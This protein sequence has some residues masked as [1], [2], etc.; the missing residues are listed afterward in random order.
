[1]G[2]RDVKIGADPLR[3]NYCTNFLTTLISMQ[4]IICQPLVWRKALVVQY[5][6]LQ[7]HAKTEIKSH[8]IWRKLEKMIIHKQHTRY[9]IQEWTQPTFEILTPNAHAKNKQKT[10]Q[11]THTHQK[12]TEFKE[13]TQNFH[14][15]SLQSLQ[16]NKANIQRH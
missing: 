3:R 7:I 6:E 8:V 1:M 2:F 13:K 9:R 5:K 12:A 10:K 11:Q 15:S 4:D 14:Y 16:K